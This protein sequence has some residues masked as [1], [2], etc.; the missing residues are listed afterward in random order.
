MKAV[1]ITESGGPEVLRL[2]DVPDPVVGPGEVVIDVVAAGV[3][4][5]DLLQRQGHYP[6]PAGAPAWPGMECSGVISAVGAGVLHWNLGDQVCALLGGGG[7]AER[8]VVPV[9]QLLPV[10]A[11]VDLVD[12][13]ALPETTCTVWSNVFMAAG[14]RPGE[15][16][17][18]R[19]RALHL[20]QDVEGETS[21]AEPPVSHDL[22]LVETPP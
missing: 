7:Y 17:L 5:A 2:A 14:L 8:V 4:R 11:G 9:G 20:G 15:L 16:L 13:A 18:V 22:G 6:P 19:V 12:A 10:P 1:V 21:M 3:N